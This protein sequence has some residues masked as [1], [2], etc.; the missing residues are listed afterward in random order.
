MPRVGFVTGGG[1]VTPKM[2]PSL[3]ASIHGRA[4]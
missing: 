3:L 4:S 2:S 1:P